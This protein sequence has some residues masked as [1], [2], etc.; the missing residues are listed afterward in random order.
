MSEQRTAAQGVTAGKRPRKAL[1]IVGVIVVILAVVGIAGWKWHEQPSFCATLCHSPMQSYYDG[2]TESEYLVRAHADAGITCLGCHEP[3]IAQQ[4]NE[5]KVKVSGDYEE[6]LRA[7]NYEN[8]FCAGSDCHGEATLLAMSA[9]HTSDLQ[10]DP[11]D[12]HVTLAAKCLSCHRM[13]RTPEPLT[14]IQCH[15][16]GQLDFEWERGAAQ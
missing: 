6:P 1:V 12:N 4:M 9:E 5:L 15:D 10:F 3:T 13:H 7:R 14:C 16:E 2:Y 8:S 11:H